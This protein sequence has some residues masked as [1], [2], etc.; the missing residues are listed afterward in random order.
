MAIVKF[1]VADIGFVETV[2]IPFG[3]MELREAKLTKLSYGYESLHYEFKVA[4]CDEHVSISEPQLCN[5]SPKKFYRTSDDAFKGKTIPLMSINLVDKLLEAG[6]NISEDCSKVVMAR[7][8]EFNLIPHYISI[9][10]A[11]IEETDED[12]I[13]KF[14]QY[15][16]ISENGITFYRYVGGGITAFKSSEDAVK[17]NPIKIYRF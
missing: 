1:K 9:A 16:T 15:D 5:D 17:L 8:K 12:I 14:R 11:E 4:G 3:D 2:L 10:D 13:V 7:Y 6:F